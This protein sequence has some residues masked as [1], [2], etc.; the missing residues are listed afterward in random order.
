M[1]EVRNQRETF[2]EDWKPGK[3]DSQANDSAHVQSQLSSRFHACFNL[4]AADNINA[5]M[6]SLKT[7]QQSLQEGL[8][9]RLL[10]VSNEAEQKIQLVVDDTKAEQ[11]RLLAYDK[12]R[13]RRQNVIYQ[14]WLQKYIVKLNEWRSRQLANLQQ[15]LL[16][17]QKSIV[18]TSQEKIDQINRDAFNLQTQILQQETDAN[19]KRTTDVTKKMYEI[20]EDG[21][22]FLGSESM[23]ELNLRIQ[24]NVGEVAPGQSCTN[25]FP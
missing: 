16:Q 14:E 10:K 7:N 15:E 9:R 23:I 4:S 1:Q 18:E 2:T 20:T 13:Q 12:E 8:R 3:P 5:V 19:K 11:K 21:R 24:A 17:Y 22:R 25:T 6:D